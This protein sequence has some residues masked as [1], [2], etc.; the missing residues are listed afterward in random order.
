[1]RQVMQRFCCITS[2]R[3]VILTMNYYHVDE[4]ACTLAGNAAYAKRLFQVM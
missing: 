4:K 3:K 2:V 1:M